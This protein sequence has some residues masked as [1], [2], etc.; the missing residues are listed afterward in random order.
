MVVVIPYLRFV[1][2]ALRF[3]L[4]CGSVVSI[5]F[6][7]IGLV[8]LAA[9]P[10]N[11]LTVSAYM[12]YAVDGAPALDGFSHFV[13]GVLTSCSGVWGAGCS[14]GWASLPEP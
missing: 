1:A 9:G 12:L 6:V 8:C 4:P 2:A 7:V 11:T 10:L 14:G 5:S 3:C 13:M